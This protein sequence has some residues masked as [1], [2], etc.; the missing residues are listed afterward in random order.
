MVRVPGHTEDLCI[1]LVDGGTDGTLAFWSDLCPTAAHVP[2][3]WVMSYD[4]FPV[5]TMANKQRW[6][7][8]AAEE[9]WLCVFQ[10]DPEVPLGRIVCDRPGRFRAEPVA[11]G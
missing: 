1:I 3:A 2:A 11:F 10:H 9:G 8:R 6:L 7:P 5:T 4:S